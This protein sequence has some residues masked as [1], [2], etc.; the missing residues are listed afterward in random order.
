MIFTSL[1]YDASIFVFVL[2]PLYSQKQSLVR[3]VLDLQQFLV[4]A[5]LPLG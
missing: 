5:D 2:M 3:N 4:D 1:K